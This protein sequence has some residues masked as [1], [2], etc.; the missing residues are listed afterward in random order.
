MVGPVVFFD[1]MGPIGFEPGRGLDVRPHPHIEL[2]TVTYLFDGA[3]LHRD[4]LGTVQ[5]IEPGA[6]HWMTAG[7][8]I[9][10]S[11]R[12]PPGQR[13]VG[14]RLSGIQVWAALPRADEEDPPSFAH[15]PAAPARVPR[16]PCKEDHR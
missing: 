10:H 3:L 13:A 16:R 12:T 14:A 7:R 8:G 4:S 1:Q 5:A 9:V 11:E 2:A 15:M 6:V